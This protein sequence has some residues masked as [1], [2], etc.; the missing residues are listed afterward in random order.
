MVI[1]TKG[2]RIKNNAPCARI[3]NERKSASKASDLYLDVNSRTA[4]VVAAA[5]GMSVLTK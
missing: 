5:K 2:V 3:V 1:N 4:K